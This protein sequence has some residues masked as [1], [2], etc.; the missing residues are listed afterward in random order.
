MLLTDI[1]FS[2]YL[3]D[4]TFSVYLENVK[5]SSPEQVYPC[6]ITNDYDFKDGST[7]EDASGV[8]PKDEGQQDDV[9]TLDDI[10]KIKAAT[11]PKCD[12]FFL[13]VAAGSENRQLNK[14]QL[15]TNAKGAAGK[16]SDFDSEGP[17][18]TAEHA[19][20]SRS[21]SRR[22]PVFDDV[23]IIPSTSE[24]V[25]YIGRCTTDGFNTSSDDSTT[26]SGNDAKRLEHVAR[27]KGSGQPGGAGKHHVGYNSRSDGCTSSSSSDEG[28]QISSPVHAV[29]G[30]VPRGRGANIMKLL[31]LHELPKPGMRVVM[32]SPK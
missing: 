10:I 12:D 29:P 4:T 1:T 30:L 8:H 15:Q 24:P 21:R 18:G 16:L 22:V 14:K 32:T 31:G 26:T 11:A 28:I 23:S 19:A 7:K 17:A 27:D 25:F 20:R 6:K 2:V 9:V 5:L 13:L 3:T